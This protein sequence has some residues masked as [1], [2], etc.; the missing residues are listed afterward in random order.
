MSHL[1]INLF[2]P[3]ALAPG[4]TLGVRLIDFG[5]DGAYQGGDD[6]A[7]IVPVTP[8]LVSQSWISLNIPLASF[9]GLASTEHLA[10]IV[11]EGTNITNFYAD[12]I[13]FV[14]D[15]SV[16]PPV[17][18]TAAPTPTYPAANV[19][20]VFSDSYTNIP[21]SDLDPNWGQL[22]DATQVSIAGNN[23]LKYDNLNYQGLQ[24]GSST[25][26]SG[27]NFLHLDYYSAD[28]DVLRVYLISPG[29][30]ETSAL[31]T[32]PTTAGW[33]SVDIPLTQFAP[34]NL[35][36]VIQLKFDGNG[37]IY[38]DNILFRN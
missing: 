36:D 19:T 13:Y 29:P 21:G 27:R 38:I 3:G 16:I 26:V 8:S 25:N 23:T 20:S 4:A 2:I 35:S 31:L 18:T 30:T 24:L 28:S 9:T 12:N 17:P 5:A 1:R 32:V 37:D 14:N 10:Q 34:V 15:G 7:F 33:N 11:L 22:T 6:S